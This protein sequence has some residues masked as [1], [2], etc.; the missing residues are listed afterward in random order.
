MLHPTKKLENTLFGWLD[1]TLTQFRSYGAETEKMILAILRCYK[2]KATPGFKTTRPLK[3]RDLKTPVF[4]TG[5]WYKT[6]QKS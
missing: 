2:L 1:G 4:N 3:L 6:K 5:I